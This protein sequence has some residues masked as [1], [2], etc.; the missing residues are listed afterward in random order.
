M[1]TIVR[2][3]RLAAKRATF[4]CDDR[5]LLARCP[6]HT[7]SVFDLIVDIHVNCQKSYPLTSVT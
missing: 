3:L 5:A 6:R 7:Q 1:A 2:S 4:S